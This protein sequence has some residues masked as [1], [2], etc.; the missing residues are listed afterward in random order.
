MY[1]SEVLCFVLCM[2]EIMGIL[3]SCEICV[4]FFH[5]ISVNKYWREKKSN[6][7]LPWCLVTVAKTNISNHYKDKTQT[8]KQNVFLVLFSCSI[9]ASHIVVHFT[10]V[11]RRSDAELCQNIILI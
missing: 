2:L 4:F 6:E 3:L 11:I 10:V 1:S 8:L 5:V 7:C 9:N